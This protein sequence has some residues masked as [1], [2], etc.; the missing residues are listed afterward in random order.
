[1]RITMR[2]KIFSLLILILA[3]FNVQARTYERLLGDDIFV[4]GELIDVQEANVDSVFAAGKSLFIS[5]AIK[6]SAYLAGQNITI[7]QKIAHSLHAAGKVVTVQG[8]VGQDVMIAAES[9]VI[10]NRVGHDLKIAAEN[11]HIEGD[12]GGDLLVAANVL[13]IKGYIAGDVIAAVKTL[14]FSPTARIDGS[15]T[16]FY[17][18]ETEKNIIPPAVIS[19]D[20]VVYKPM[21]GVEFDSEE[22]SGISGLIFTILLLTLILFGVVMGFRT[23]IENAYFAGRSSIWRS[24]GYGFFALAAV[25]GSIF[26]SIITVIGIPLAVLTVIVLAVMS[27]AGYLLGGYF[28]VCR[29][30]QKWKGAV[31]SSM[32][33]VAITTILSVLSVLALSNIPICGLVDNADTHYVWCGDRCCFSLLFCTIIILEIIITHDT[34]SICLVNCLLYNFKQGEIM[35]FL[36]IFT[37]STVIFFNTLNFF[38]KMNMFKNMTKIIICGFALV[39]LIACS[40][41]GSGESSASNNGGTDPTDPGITLTSGNSLSITDDEISSSGED[42]SFVL[43][44]TV[45]VSVDTLA[46]SNLTA[47]STINIVSIEKVPVNGLVTEATIVFDFVDGNTAA[48][49]ITIA[50]G[51]LENATQT[52]IEDIVISVD[53]GPRITS[54]GKSQTLFK[55]NFSYNL[56]FSEDIN[57]LASRSFSH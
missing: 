51:V 32:T 11:V 16:I 22:D 3:T 57:G 6:G 39:G 21:I 43:T 20:R 53:K 47:S 56:A 35:K 8:E 50:T 7:K 5:N 29:I 38:G 41:G 31:P 19:A 2:N 23:K 4:A 27:F 46:P 18:D 30:W 44:F 54:L 13:T 1:M 33:A 12:I 40:S 34:Q 52:N 24:L 17:S 15:L 49:T 37:V 9:A 36:N 10:S 55:G 28:I 14:Q 45:D 42:Y 25:F 26:V 48:G